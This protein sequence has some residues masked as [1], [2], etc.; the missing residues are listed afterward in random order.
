MWCAVSQIKIIGPY[1]FD[2]K[3]NSDRYIMLQNFFI[4]VL[5]E[6]DE[7]DIQNIWFQKDGAM[8]HTA[9]TS[10]QV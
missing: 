7:I 6:L 3:N 8:A 1:Y 5:G 9:R 10:M 2:E 4:L